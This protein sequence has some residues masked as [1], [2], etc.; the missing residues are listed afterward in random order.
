M[1]TLFLEGSGLVA[2]KLNLTHLSVKG[3]ESD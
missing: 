3:A 2:P 1:G